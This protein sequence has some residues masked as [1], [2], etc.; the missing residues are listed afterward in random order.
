MILWH[1]KCL[2]HHLRVLS[3][4][5]LILFTACNSDATI[6]KI[7]N[8]IPTIAITSHEDGST[9][10][11]GVSA[12]FR[13]QASDDDDPGDTLTVTWYVD[14]DIVCEAALAEADGSSFCDIA[15]GPNAQRVVVNVSDP[16]NGGASD[17]ISIVVTP[18]DAPTV[19]ILAPLNEAVFYSDQ[20]IEFSAQIADNEDPASDLTSEWS[21]SID[22]VLSLDTTVD[23]LGTLQDF[24]NLSEGEHAIE[25]LVTDTTGK[26]STDSVVV[27]VRGPN[28]LPACSITE[29]LDGTAVV[30]GE[31]R[32]LAQ[33][34]DRH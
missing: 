10:L 5:P 28:C 31:N 19:S 2:D 18:T 11:E 29:P 21:S 6:D 1:D 32:G 23:T 26:T 27:E 33:V 9:F 12:Q 16:K 24:T 4:L 7:S 34:G 17:E 25:I 20:L 8:K 22:G 13:A 3:I 15:F 14:D 30:Y